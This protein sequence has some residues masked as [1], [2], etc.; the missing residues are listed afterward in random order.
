MNQ[1]SFQGRN[2]KYTIYFKCEAAEFVGFIVR[3]PIYLTN[4]VH[5]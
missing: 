4:P 3:G 1:A 2:Y 5:K